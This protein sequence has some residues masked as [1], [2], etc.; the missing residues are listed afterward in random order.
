MIETLYKTDTPEKE[1]SEC[2]LLVLTPRPTSDGRVYSFMEEHGWWDDSELR[3]VRKVKS[4][5]A[6]EN[7]T[8]EAAESLYSRTKQNLAALGFTHSVVDS[9][10]HRDPEHVH[11][12]HCTKLASA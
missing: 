9:Y 5:S 6:N 12:Q 2:C 7:L 10:S 1:K 11:Q 4:I 8:R 3:Y